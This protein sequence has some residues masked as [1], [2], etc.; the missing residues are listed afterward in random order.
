MKLRIIFILVIILFNA[1]FAT[2]LYNRSPL[3]S[4]KLCLDSLQL[5]STYRN[6]SSF[7]LN[8]LKV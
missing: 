8:L 4:I 5:I 2:K 3:E 1:I 7:F 6:I